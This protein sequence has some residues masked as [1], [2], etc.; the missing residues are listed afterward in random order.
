MLRFLIAL[1]A[2]PVLAG[3]IVANGA[4]STKHS[5]ATASAT[6]RPTLVRDVKASADP[7]APGPTSKNDPRVP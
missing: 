4:S 2:L 5:S 7:L 6:L 1:L 3:A